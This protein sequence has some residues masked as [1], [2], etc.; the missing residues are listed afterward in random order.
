[1]DHI[2]TLPQ[3]IQKTKKYNQSLHLAFAVYEIVF[4]SI[5]TWQYCTLS[6]YAISVMSISKFSC[7]YPITGKEFESKPI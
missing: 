5:E 6:N 3:V 2:Q 4:D 7:A 1:M